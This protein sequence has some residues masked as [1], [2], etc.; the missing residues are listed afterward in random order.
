MIFTENGVFH[1]TNGSVSYI[2]NI[3]KNGQLGHLYY[4]KAMRPGRDYSH[5]GPRDNVNP[6]TSHAF[7]GD[8]SFSLETAAQ[9]YPVYGK[10][11]FREA[12]VLIEGPDGE[13]IADFI[14]QGHKIIEGKPQM[15]TL[16]STYV[17]DDQEAKTM[18]VTM[19][20]EKSRV[21]VQ[22]LY[23]I[24]AELPVITRSVKVL[25]H[26]G[27]AVEI[28]RLLSLSVDFPEDHYEMLHLSGAWARERYV[29]TRTLAP[30][31]QRISSQRGSSSHQHN[32]F[33][34]LKRP[35]ATEHTGEVIGMNF[36][37]SGNF[38]SQAEVDHYRTT[39]IQ[40]GIHPD[41]FSWRLEPQETFEA[42]EAVL[43]YS[44]EGL[45]GL[46]QAMHKLTYRHIISK[47]WQ[48]ENRPVLINNW[49]ATYFDFNEDKLV[50]FAKEAK[51]LGIDMFVLDDGWF[52]Q[53]N[54][55]STSLGDWFTDKSKLPDGVGALAE[56]IK[57]EGLQFGLWF[58]PEMISPNSGLGHEHPEWMIGKDDRHRTLGRNQYVLD[59]SNPE[60]VDHLYSRMSAIIEETG[61][62]Y[63]KW[64]MNRNITE[65][66]S[67]YLSRQGEFFHRYILGVYDLY[68]RLTSK[69]P[70]VLFESCAGG[71]G[72]FDLGMMYYAPQA[73][74]SDNTDAVDRLKIQYGTSVAYPLSS[75]GSHVSA[76]PNHQTLREN[77]LAFRAAV[78][79]F[80]TF[81][82]ELDPER[83]SKED[84]RTVQK[85]IADYKRIQPLIHNGLFYRLSSPFET[86]IT[87]WMIYDSIT[88]DGI[89]GWYKPFASPNPENDQR[90]RLVGLEE[91]VLYEVD[92]R[93]FY[94]DELMY[95]GIDTGVEFNG[96]NHTE[97]TRGGDEQFC[98]FFIKRVSKK[99]GGS[100]GK[101]L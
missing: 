84:K 56:R 20:D 72:R 53:R 31:I 65:P 40:M 86:D 51:E 94:G 70:E 92:D 12:A 47:R 71:G 14:Y 44:E 11:D 93:K 45:N 67:M 37:Y 27:S 18:V 74:A 76:V 46:S 90:L 5:L 63:I 26:G 61:L 30:G 7:S 42:P 1:L 15:G 80:G 88:G 10:G 57:G 35:Q 32:P 4:G 73:W 54:D 83:L 89:V 38:L 23:T 58:E 62:T 25:N 68:E 49:E 97:M 85:Q 99:G 69:Y 78:A 24:F 28:K 36:I 8:Q 2:F 34:A 52:G 81:G 75:I 9:E 87:A 33:L 17:Q 82:F 48:K 77:S 98:L 21:K 13:I 91:E 16:P 101:A 19:E 96:A 29:T 55:D 50:T 3:M 60:V 59:F 66:Y 79:Y 22:L 39:R 100:R 43:A 64:D 6:N 95:A 41:R